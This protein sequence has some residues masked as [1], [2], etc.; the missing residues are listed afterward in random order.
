MLGKKVPSKILPNIPSLKLT[1]LRPWKWMVGMLVSFLF[2]NWPIFSGA[3][4]VSFRE[5]S[6]LGGWKL[7]P[8]ENY[9]SQKNWIISPGKC[10]CP[11]IFWMSFIPWDPIICKTNHQP[12]NSA[13]QTWP[14][15]GMVKTFTTWSEVERRGLVT[16]NEKHQQKVTNFSSPG[17]RQQGSKDFMLWMFP[18]MVVPQ[19]TPKWS[20]LVGKPMVVGY[21][22]FRK[23]PYQPWQHTLTLKNSTNAYSSNFWLVSIPGTFRRVSR[24]GRKT[25]EIPHGY[26]CG[27]RLFNGLDKDSPKKKHVATKTGGQR[28]MLINHINRIRHKNQGKSFDH[29]WPFCGWNKIVETEA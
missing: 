15:L 24:V 23:P 12:G 4:A 8:S 6:L 1:W 25:V 5:G 2:G 9:A 7:N 19:N 21:H 13:K 18:K 14:F 28:A 27:I 11:V 29:T 3:F 17:K 20:F 26:P 16:S 22:H 10:S